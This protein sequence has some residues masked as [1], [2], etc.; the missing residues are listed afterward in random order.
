[1]YNVKIRTD[2]FNLT[3]HYLLDL[4]PLAN[5][6]PKNLQLFSTSVHFTNAGSEYLMKNAV[7]Q[8]LKIINND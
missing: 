3:T 4:M 5:E 2:K 8:I 1:M 6:A 7:N